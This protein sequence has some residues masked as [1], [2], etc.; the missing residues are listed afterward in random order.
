MSNRFLAAFGIGLVLIAVAVAG[1]LYM[2]RGAHVDLPG[3]VLKVR[4]A[5]LDENS[6]VAVIDFRASNPSDYPFVIRTVSVILEDPDGAQHPSGA[7]SDADAKALFQAIPLLGE[8]YNQTMMM[9][10]TIPA[11]GSVDRMVAARFEAPESRLEA[12]KRLIVRIEEID[13][14]VFELSDK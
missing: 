12:R 9:K 4:T 5:P 14:K 6:S 10:E 2:Q 11:H 8:K 13:G 3:K 7:A 1:V